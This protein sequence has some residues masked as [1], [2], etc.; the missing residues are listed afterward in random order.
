VQQEAF[1]ARLDDRGERRFEE[2]GR[3]FGA[4]AERVT[5][6]EQVE[7]ALARC[8]AALE[9]GQAAVLVARVTPL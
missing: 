3:A 5:E 8:F 6:P 1:R 9:R 4:H 7:A 2:V